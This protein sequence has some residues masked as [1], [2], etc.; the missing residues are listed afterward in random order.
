MGTCEVQFSL[1]SMNTKRSY[2]IIKAITDNTHTQTQSYTRTYRML[3]CTS[4]QFFTCSMWSPLP[5]ILRTGISSLRFCSLNTLL[6][7]TKKSS[8]VSFYINNS[9]S[10]AGNKLSILLS[11]CKQR[12]DSTR[13][14]PVHILLLLSESPRRSRWEQYYHHSETERSSSARVDHFK[15]SEMIKRYLSV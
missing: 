2:K 14:L 10:R 5:W 3:R 13:T 4:K 15:H 12:A 1:A 9:A 11:L 8:D 7:K 6:C